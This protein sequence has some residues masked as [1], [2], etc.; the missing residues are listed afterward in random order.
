MPA[1]LFWSAG[2][3]TIANDCRPAFPLKEQKCAVAS[4]HVFDVPK[5][6]PF[7]SWF[8]FLQTLNEALQLDEWPSA[9]FIFGRWF[10]R[11]QERRHDLCPRIPCYSPARSATPS[12][13][14]PD[15]VAVPGALQF[16][17]AN[18]A[19][20]ALV[21][22]RTAATD[23]VPPARITSGASLLMRA[24]RPERHAAQKPMLR[25]PREMLRTHAASWPPQRL[26]TAS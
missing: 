11:N 3:M 9:F 4:L 20:M 17:L 14:K 26:R 8:A 13:A 7:L 1:P 12:Q 22:S 23:A 5:S 15:V 18:T 19:G 10:E 21:R 16:A 25:L 24:A 6:P 2:Y